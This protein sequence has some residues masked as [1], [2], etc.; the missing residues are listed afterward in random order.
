MNFGKILDEERQSEPFECSVC[1]DYRQPKT[2]HIY[3]I[4]SSDQTQESS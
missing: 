1:N 3:F 4:N 2:Y